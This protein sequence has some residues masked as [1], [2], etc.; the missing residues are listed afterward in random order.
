MKLLVDQGERVRHGLETQVMELQDKLKQAQGS[1]SAKEAL[2]KVGR[3][4][5]PAASVS[6][7]LEHP[8]I[9]SPPVSPQYGQKIADYGYPL[10]CFQ[11]GSVVRWGVEPR[12]LGILESREHRY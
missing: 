11:R 9:C 1:E 4:M 7:Q 12:R 5:A 10:V 6:F 3:R 8:Q 2:R